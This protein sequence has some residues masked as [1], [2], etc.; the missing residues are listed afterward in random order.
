MTKRIRKPP[1]SAEKVRDWL[2]RYEELGESPPHIAKSDGYDVRTVRKQLDRIRQEREFREAKQMVLRQALE[3]HYADICTFAE[4]LRDVFVV[5]T[6]D[7]IRMSYVPK[8]DPMWQALREHL[9]RSPMWQDINTWERVTEEFKSSFEAIKSRTRREAEAET[10]LR[11]IS[12][13][14]E[15]GLIEGLPETIA[16]HVMSLARG[17]RG[18][19]IL[20]FSRM[21]RD[22]GILLKWGAFE[23][24][25]VPENT[26]E[27]IEKACH[28][29]KERALTWEESQS[30]F[31]QVQDLVKVRDDLTEE[32]TGIILRR[33]VGG[34]CRYCPY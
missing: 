6:P 3:R 30:L 9:P 20:E 1:V 16:F 7:R 2:K 23:V 10:G 11:F 14:G 27:K 34:R 15:I 19:D 31:K 26:L 17:D 32:L 12:A 29:L 5:S 28:A 22:A 8:M 21:K 24:A 25:N 33:V 18:I 4:K 13:P